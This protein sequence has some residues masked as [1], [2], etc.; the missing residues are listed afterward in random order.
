[1]ATIEAALREARCELHAEGTHASFAAAVERARA[2]LAAAGGAAASVS[3]G[4]FMAMAVRGHSGYGNAFLSRDRRVREHIDAFL[5]VN[6]GF[7]SIHDLEAF[8]VEAE[9]AFQC[10]VQSR[11]VSAAE[12]D[13]DADAP[14]LA[15]AITCYDDLLLGPLVR[16]PSVLRAGL[17]HE[18]MVRMPEP[19]VTRA[20][21]VLIILELTREGPL[22]GVDQA[23][24]EARIELKYQKPCRDLGL[25]AGLTTTL[26]QN[27][28]QLTRNA[29]A[30]A[31]V[32]AR[33]REEAERA[34]D[35]LLP[36][37]LR[38][39]REAMEAEV[40][41]LCRVCQERTVKLQNVLGGLAQLQALSG[42]ARELERRM[43]GWL[44]ADEPPG[45]ELA[46]AW[47]RFTGEKLSKPVQRALMS[48]TDRERDAAAARLLPRAMASLQSLAVLFTEMRGLL[49]KLST[50]AAEAEAEAEATAKAAP[51]TRVAA[52]EEKGSGSNEGSEAEEGSEKAAGAEQEAKEAEA[53]GGRGSANAGGAARGGVKTRP[54]VSL[55]RL[56]EAATALSHG[57][58]FSALAALERELPRALGACSFAE[59]GRGSSLLQAMADDAELAAE[60][61]GGRPGGL[62]AAAVAGGGGGGP[63][64]E[65]VV[66]LAA[67]ILATR[68]R[69]G[70]AAEAEGADA[71]VAAVDA[72]LRRH[73]R[74]PNV[75]ALGHGPLGRLV[76]EAR[77]WV[78]E[79]A[80]AAAGGGAGGIAAATAAAV[81]PES[82]LAPPPLT[83]V[84]GGTLMASQL[85]ATD[86]AGAAAKC[87][88]AAPMLTELGSW[89]MW[90]EAFESQLGPLRQYLARTPRSG[91]SWRA[92]EAPGGRLFKV[93]AGLGVEGSTEVFRARLDAMDAPGMAAAL[94]ALVADAGGVEPAPLRYLEGLVEAR[95]T[96]WVD[97]AEATG[98]VGRPLPHASGSV[99]PSPLL[100]LL[101]CC[102]DCLAAIPLRALRAALAHSVLLPPLESAR[103]LG[104]GWR[105]AL[106][107]AAVSQQHRSVLHEL[108]CDLGCEEWC[109]DWADTRTSPLLLSLMAT[110]S[111][112]VT[113]MAGEIVQGAEPAGPLIAEER[114]RRRE[115]AALVVERIRH[116]YGVDKLFTDPDALD[117]IRCNT[118]R[119][120]NAV[121]Q[122]SAQLYSKDLHFV[123]E[124]LQ[125]A[126]DNSYDP[127]VVPCLEFVLTPASLVVLNN[128]RGFMERDIR[129][130]SDVNK[131][132]KKKKKGYI[133]KKGIGFKSVFQVSDAPEVHS[134]GFHVSFDSVAHGN[135]GMVLPSVVPPYSGAELPSQLGLVPATTCIRLPLRGGLRGGGGSGG[136]AAAVANLR[137]PLSEVDPRLL[138]FL[139]KL[140]R[141]AV[142]DATGM[143]GEGEGEGAALLAGAAGGSPPPPTAVTVAAGSGLSVQVLKESLGG[144]Q[145]SLRFGPAGRLR[146]Q[147]WLIV[148]DS[149]APTVDRGDLSIAELGET[150]VSL[151]FDL[152]AARASAEAAA[153]ASLGL[154]G[155]AEPMSAAGGRPSR[156]AR[157]EVFAYLPTRDYGLR[158]VV[159]ADFIVTTSRESLD[160]SSPYNQ[161]LV[162]RIPQLF[163]RSLVALE[164]LDSDP[165]WADRPMPPFGWLNYWLDCLPLPDEA[166][167]IF[168]PL[169]RRIA[170]A[171]RAA[172][173]LP[174]ACGRRVSPARQ[175]LRVCHDPRVS[176][177]L[178]LPEMQLALRD[179][180]LYFLH[181]G[182]APL[183][184]SPPLRALLGVQ[185][186]TA[187]D[188]VSLLGALLVPTDGEGRPRE[189][190][191]LP[192]LARLL[193]VVFCMLGVEGAEGP[194]AT[195]AQGGAA[196]AGAGS[197]GGSAAGWQVAPAA[198]WADPSSTWQQGWQQGGGAARRAQRSAASEAAWSTL[199]SLPLLQLAGRTERVA[200]NEARE[201]VFFIPGSGEAG[202][203]TGQAPATSRARRPAGRSP[204]HG[205]VATSAGGGASL[206]AL[207]Q[208]VGLPRNLEPL[209]SPLRDTAG[210]GAGTGL[211][212]LS[213]DLLAAVPAEGGQ[214]GVLLAGLAQLGVRQLAAAD[215]FES[216]I[217]PLMR[218]EAAASGTLP[219]ATLV[220]CLAF[221]LAAGLLGGPDAPGDGGSGATRGSASGDWLNQGG[222]RYLTDERGHPSSRL[223]G[224]LGSQAWARQELDLLGDP[225]YDTPLGQLR[226][227]AVL[228]TDKGRIRCGPAGATLLQPPEEPLPESADVYLPP[229]LCPRGFDLRRAFPEWA[230]RHALVLSDAYH[231]SEAAS[232]KAWLWL[233]GELGA[234]PFLR[235]QE[236]SVFVWPSGHV[237]PPEALSP[238]PGYYAASWGGYGAA[239]EA[240]PAGPIVGGRRQP[241][242]EAMELLQ[243][244]WAGMAD[245][246]AAGSGAAVSWPWGR[247]APLPHCAPGSVYRMEDVCCRALGPL[248]DTIL[249]PPADSDADGD[250]DSK[251]DVFIR[252]SLSPPRLP[253][254]KAKQL[255]LLAET[256]QELWEE[257]GYSRAARLV[258]PVSPVYNYEAL[259]E[260]RAAAAG[261]P[262]LY[263]GATLPL[264]QRSLA[265]EAPPSSFILQLRT[266]RWLPCAL[267]YA[268][269]AAEVLPRL[270][271]LLELF[272][273]DLPLPFIAP[274]ASLPPDSPL[275]AA[276]GIPQQPSADLV[277]SILRRLSDTAAAAAAEAAHPAVD[278]DVFNV[279]D[280][281]SD[282]DSQGSDGVVA[283]A[284]GVVDGRDDSAADAADGADDAAEPPAEEVPKPAEKAEPEARG[285]RGAGLRGKATRPVR[286][287]PRGKGGGGG[288]DGPLRFSTERLASVYRFLESAAQQHQGP[289]VLVAVCRAFAEEPLIWVP[290]PVA[291]E[292]AGSISR[293][294]P[295]RFYR[296]S[297][298]VLSDPTGV[299]EQLA[300]QRAAEEAK[301]NGRLEGKGDPS[302]VAVRLRV[303]DVHYP[304]K[305]LSFFEDLC[306]V[307]QG[308]VG[309]YGR[310]A[311]HVLR[312]ERPLVARQP[313]DADYLA[314]LG[315]VLRRAERPTREAAAQVG[316]ILATWA[317]DAPTSVAAAATSPAASTAAASAAAATAALRSELSGLRFLPTL[318][319]VW[320]SPEE[321]ALWNDLPDL[322][323]LFGSSPGVHVVDLELLSSGA[324]G[325][326]A[327]TSASQQG[328]SQLATVAGS[329]NG[330][331]DRNRD[332]KGPAAAGSDPRLAALLSGLGVQRL[333]EFVHEEVTHRG[334]QP[335]AA[336]ERLLRVALPF[337]QRFLASQRPR[338]YAALRGAVAARLEQLRVFE[339]EPGSLRV[340]RTLYLPGRP[341]M[342]ATP[343]ARPAVLRLQQLQQEEQ[344]ERRAAPEAGA[345]ECAPA[346]VSLLVGDPRNVIKICDE[347]TR[348][349]TADSAV[350]P[351]LSSFL[352]CL[353]LSHEQDTNPDRDERLEA[354]E[355]YACERGCGALPEGEATWQ[356]R[357]GELQPAAAGTDLPP[358]PAAAAAGPL[359]PDPDL[360]LVESGA[361]RTPVA[362]RRARAQQQQEQ[363]E[364]PESVPSKTPAPGPA[365]APALK[366][367]A[368]LA[369]AQS[370][371]ARASDAPGEGPAL[372]SDQEAPDQEDASAAPT[373]G[374]VQEERGAAGSEAPPIRSTPR[375]D[376]WRDVERWSYAP[377][378]GTARMG[379]RVPGVGALIQGIVGG[380]GDG[381]FRA[382]AGGLSWTGAGAG[383]CAAPE[384][385]WQDWLEIPDVA[386]G[387]EGLGPELLAHLAQELSGAVAAAVA[388]SGQSATPPAPVGMA[389][390]A[391]V[392]G[393]TV[394][395]LAAADADAGASG[396]TAS[397]SAGAAAPDAA[398]VAEAG[399]AAGLG[400]GVAL[401]V[402]NPSVARWGEALVFSLLR[403]D[404]SLAEQGWSVDWVSSRPESHNAPYDILLTRGSTAGGE[405]TAE[406]VYIEVKS[407]VRSEKD[408]F[409]ISAQ[410]LALAQQAGR[411]YVIFRVLGAGSL[412]SS[413]VLVLADP[414]A[415]CLRR[416]LQLCVLTPEGA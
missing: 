69:P 138:L 83:A 150:E 317:K 105:E 236:R 171:A 251:A 95:W 28:K 85:A 37:V 25:T 327:S 168:S 111:A 301:E 241:T 242:A 164:A 41:A 79:S 115:A 163:A 298:V 178:A 54:A 75:E 8:I 222:G 221:P 306:V 286:S 326:G 219:D 390:A 328:A 197:A 237:P 384:S 316:A 378:T 299:L 318:A 232:K 206:A 157:Q 271:K 183:H 38:R 184:A 48:R 291:G 204:T 402:S 121:M 180:D 189:R 312:R 139:K 72:A 274:S 266:R 7:A 43:G 260:L 356:M 30:R 166:Q 148:S 129:A 52:D 308:P 86:A 70:A 174:T 405:A 248:L 358:A 416:Q 106:L 249:P 126:E 230:A 337:A 123:M 357:C 319:G 347:I 399:A 381:G 19:K 368:D 250:A 289:A 383:P 349:F 96:A 136:A 278:I 60:L 276:M 198:R 410:E 120:G 131:S 153:A 80:A 364:Q 186:F 285:E 45:D 14:A 214:R 12:E 195:A 336:A 315:A 386:A 268:A 279:A 21:M 193:V 4:A 87:L 262:M 252:C 29:P 56:R 240:Q 162:A 213:P 243:S 293:L 15:P 254:A 78:A 282:E 44:D 362:E 307:E 16:H 408:S 257:C 294:R 146:E 393:G 247:V 277:L 125:N 188:M 334:L 190:L 176:E 102:L 380:G 333:S 388:G 32:E 90:E 207:L 119:V 346:P 50:A 67:M 161:M 154:D 375:P 42:E 112:P 303:L 5:A 53:D 167:D 370:H 84:G 1:M 366:Q 34:R 142:T 284:D 203:G 17:A 9:E 332:G 411:N 202:S 239:G 395:P 134:N 141:V 117:T 109:R 194:D 324:S 65:E 233:L 23:A 2:K 359:P 49:H 11:A 309:P 160:S 61:T 128:E 374:E 245:P 147:R 208:S 71:V 217:L 290:D 130:L 351:E 144:G 305:T 179:A 94:L 406:R 149:F 371:P 77:G 63:E 140:K 124:L 200:P 320:C 225:M 170:E 211:Q 263:W 355:R 338:Q 215:V 22:S 39:T 205:S 401:G 345:A 20:D 64:L 397:A 181:E 97:A 270:P 192:V 73:Y 396:D 116:T 36:P 415:M 169:S 322:A 100:P 231:K 354:A 372:A 152:E 216:A 92:V 175:Q 244:P 226:R 6:R 265:Y 292:A 352:L 339:V 182:V 382:A 156:P 89:A 10:R 26:V 35:E 272:G 273:G 304:P 101:R 280:G 398:A 118:E 172:V 33:V 234:T 68:G 296:A 373:A 212:F 99:D 335:G 353:L 267:G 310:P 321:G 159:N 88:D 255:L 363:Q 264:G 13:S 165:G 394:A 377:P 385:T 40:E 104:R 31:A 47:V 135:L 62:G 331:G 187:R 27:L 143:E 412:E 287:P 413:R 342:A 59:L 210:A 407:S 58:S 391:A 343:E 313:A 218:S 57:L 3:H 348:L 281:S 196:A 288:G 158:F 93:P 275:L 344:P 224:Q 81:L 403:R 235:L 283:A 256:L 389:A 414:W 127:D 114:K 151:A 261:Y 209:L 340:I 185:D 74:V 409:E 387:D 177:L 311:P 300:A 132:T 229:A 323:R 295:G 360:A 259:D 137:K 227:C 369:T 376:Y 330:S 113:A 201:P 238:T 108:G 103:I 379:P 107:A 199:R 269:S 82:G 223:S 314:A 51:S 341:P 400:S 350:D 329:G 55:R 228:I 173:L 253:A 66:A 24:L 392:A 246:H 367:A 98:P 302:S 145:V 325:G 110:A 191:K 258:A 361:W 46:A 76:D 18:G 91:A 220:A 297:E 404:P 155:D 365:D 133:G 122:L